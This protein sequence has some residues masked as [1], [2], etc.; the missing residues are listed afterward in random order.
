MGSLTESWTPRLLFENSDSSELF[1][2]YPSSLAPRTSLTSHSP[3]PSP[4]YCLPS[5]IYCSASTFFLF[6]YNLLPLL[7]HF[8][9]HLLP[10]L[11]VTSHLRSSSSSPPGHFPFILVSYTVIFPSLIQI[12]T[13]IIFISAHYL[14]NFPFSLPFQCLDCCFAGPSFFNLLVAGKLT[15]TGIHPFKCSK[16]YPIVSRSQRR[17][18]R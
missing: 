1:A 5:G 7:S 10:L 2:L 11:Q 14:L 9:V 13:Q 6:S 18:T 3:S 4:F 17:A 8:P 16:G 15:L 12:L